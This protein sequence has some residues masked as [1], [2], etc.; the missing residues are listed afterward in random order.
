MSDHQIHIPA[1]P[2]TECPACGLP[3]EITDRFVLG[4]APGP[5]EHVKVVCVARHWF[6]LPV[7]Q[8]PAAGVSGTSR[9]S[10]RVVPSSASESDPRESKS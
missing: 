7:E 4:G 6:T 1:E 10:L 2:L 8:L 5:V 9:T 3:A